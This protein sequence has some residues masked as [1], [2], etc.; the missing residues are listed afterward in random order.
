MPGFRPLG[1]LPIAGLEFPLETIQFV[2]TSTCISRGF[3][4]NSG[5]IIERPGD[6][7]D[8]GHILYDSVLADSVTTVGAIKA[9]LDGNETYAPFI[10]FPDV[11]IP[12]GALVDGVY[13]VLTAANT[14][15]YDTEVV[16]TAEDI[17]FSPSIPGTSTLSNLT[18]RSRTSASVNWSIP[19]VVP[20][21]AVT[22]PNLV[23]IVQELVDRSDWLDPNA[24]AVTFFLDPYVV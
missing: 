19:A 13:L 23:T 15:A 22:S 8:D 20:G 16:V 5:F 11:P 21:T 17:R 24:H 6:S 3:V 10:R 14:I 4:A 18:G 1:S 2:G 12:E 9:G 7:S